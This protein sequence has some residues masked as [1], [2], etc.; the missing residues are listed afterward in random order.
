MNTVIEEISD[1]RKKLIVNVP[2]ATIE[3]LEGEVVGEFAKQA[4]IP[5]FRP[6]KAPANIIKKRYAKDIRN[7]TGNKVAQKA[8]ESAVESSKIK[9]MALVEA[10]GGNFEVG[11]DN[12]YQFTVDLVPEFELPTYKGLEISAPSEDVTDEEIEETIEEIRRQR[13]SFEEVNR[14]AAEGDYVKLS[15]EGKLDDQP[16]SEIAPDAPQLAKQENTW[17]EAGN[18]DT[19]GIAGIAECL[20]GLKP[21]DKSEA[22]HTFPEDF[23]IEA[24]AGKTVNYAFEV[25]EVRERKLPELNEEFYQSLQVENHDGLIE[26]VKNELIQRKKQEVLTR[27]RNQIAEKLA[28]GV[29][30]AIPETS[31][32]QETQQVIEEIMQVNMQRGVPLEEFEKHKE[33]V[34]ANARQTA[35]HRAKVNFLLLK[36]AEEERITAENDDFNRIIMSQAMQSRTKPDQIVKELQ[37]DRARVDRMRR[38]IILGKALDKVVTEAKIT[39]SEE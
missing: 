11:K 13:A 5:G 16:L 29:D 30:F 24:L 4:K 21:G 18:A 17:E 22:E 25:H 20:T 36:I 9:V 26:R 39:I 23:N 31:V 27:K 15:Y 37:K 8:Y 3:S 12:E 1:T 34:Y 35:L 33:E 28:E 19:P 14:E 38:D 32:E 10:D 2:A 7:E 6:G